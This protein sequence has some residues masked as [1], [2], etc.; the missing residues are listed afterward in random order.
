[1]FQAIS[2]GQELN[3]DVKVSTPRLKT[4]DP[5][6][7]VNLENAVREFL[8]NN[9]WTDKDYEDFEK[10]EGS[11]NITIKEEFSTNS[12]S[13]DFFFQSLRPVYASN[14]KTQ[15]INYVDKDIPFRYELNQPIQKSLNAYFDNLSSLLTFYA[16]TFIAFD[17]DTFSP[18]GGDV[19]FE[20]AQNLLNA[21]PLDVQD[22]DK[23]WS[24]KGGNRNRYWM[25]ENALNPK[26][27]S[28]RQATYEYH[29]LSL[30][31]MHKDADRAKAIMTSAITSID[32]VN[33]NLPNSMIVQMFIDSKRDEII[34]VYKDAARGEQSKIYD[35]MVRIDPS[36]ASQYS[37][38]R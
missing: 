33:K 15:I 13:A 18:S 14:Y 25:I 10:I 35:I 4:A 29:R 32:Q 3:I 37:A 27:K 17:H 6:L 9:S 26:V 2:Y 28:L 30:D 34:E 12:F 5:Q 21:I 20:K 16:M 1:M 8:N 11:L 19:Y 31:T 38:I 24:V 23:A 36:Q 7:F 22:T